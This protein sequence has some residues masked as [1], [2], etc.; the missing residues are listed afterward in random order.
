MPCFVY[1]SLRKVDSY[2][3]LAQRD[4]FDVLPESLLLLLGELRFVMEVHL[5]EY[6]QAAGRGCR[7]DTRASAQPGLAPAIAAPGNPRHRQ[8]SGLHALPTR[9]ITTT[10]SRLAGAPVR[11][12]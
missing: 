8:P 10:D 5:D 6:A 1:A 7:A 3:W 12:G 11:H 2:V 4:D 9:V